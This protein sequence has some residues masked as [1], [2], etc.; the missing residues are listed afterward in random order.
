MKIQKKYVSVLAAVLALAVIAGC[1]VNPSPAETPA[2]TPSTEATPMGQCSTAEECLIAL[3]GLD[4]IEL[5][6]AG[7]ETISANVTERRV[8]DLEKV[9]EISGLDENGVIEGWIYKSWCRLDVPLDD[10]MLAGAMERDGDWLCVDGP[11]AAYMLRRPDGSYD[12]GGGMVLNDKPAAYNGDYYE[13]VW[14]AYCSARGME[15]LY[16]LDWTGVLGAQELGTVSAHRFDGDGW[17]VYV[18]QGLW[19]YDGNP[20]S[21]HMNWL[22][23]SAYGTGS[24]VLIELLDEPS[25]YSERTVVSES[26]DAYVIEVPAGERR[27]LITASYDSAGEAYCELAASR[28]IARSFRLWDGTESGAEPDYPT[29]DEFQYAENAALHD[30]VYAWASENLPGV[31]SVSGPELVSSYGSQGPGNGVTLETWSYLAGDEPRAVIVLN[32]GGRYDIIHEDSADALTARYGSLEEAGPGWWAESGLEYAVDLPELWWTVPDTPLPLSVHA[33]RQTVGGVWSAHLPAKGWLLNEA[34]EGVW[35]L[36]AA[37][38]SG[39]YFEIRFM[40]AGEYE[41]WY[42]EF[43]DGGSSTPVNGGV[44][45]TGD[46]FLSHTWYSREDSE[47]HGVVMTLSWP[48]DAAAEGATLLRVLKSVKLL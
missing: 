34:D 43:T 48:N 11:L 9:C 27:F 36:E 24:N 29:A 47:P 19:K 7:G 44:Y 15:P 30:C 26:G 16:L 32:D 28:E 3:P 14:D 41:A 18:P 5:A 21:S 10:V 46:G 40:D 37:S 33:V 38:G 23:S 1:A 31:N 6:A 4:S 8:S 2:V 17:Y 35:R 20:L 12:P 13:L 25:E 22:F 45:A 39:A 42:N